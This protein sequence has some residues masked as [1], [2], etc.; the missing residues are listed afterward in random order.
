MISSA[1]WFSWK[2][3]SAESM[4]VQL[5]DEFKELWHENER[6]LLLKYIPYLKEVWTYQFLPSFHIQLWFRIYKIYCANDI[7]LYLLVEP[8]CLP[9]MKWKVCNLGVCVQTAFVF[10]TL[11]I[12][13][14]DIPDIISELKKWSEVCTLFSTNSLL[15]LI[16][17]IGYK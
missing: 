14:F 16:W 6:V 4:A 17:R 15:I 5:I 11:I 8:E 1:N 12:M 9:W 13:T 2:K 7:S 10:E 3:L